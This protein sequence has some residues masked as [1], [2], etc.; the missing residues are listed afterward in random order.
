MLSTHSVVLR[1]QWEVS[2]CWNPEFGLRTKTIF[3]VASS[4]GCRRADVAEQWQAPCPE[5]RWE[6][7]APGVVPIPHAGG[8]CL[9]AATAWKHCVVFGFCEI[10]RPPLW[11]KGTSLLR[12]L[13]TLLAGGLSASIFEFSKQKCEASKCSGG[14]LFM[15]WAIKPMEK[16]TSGLKVCPVKQDILQII[17]W[18]YSTLNEAFHFRSN[19]GQGKG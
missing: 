5:G 14:I 3:F 15:G 6:F 19:T 17:V 10:P 18:S 1:E 11:V 16:L 9:P 12:G 2:I 8:S 4:M 13:D 7:A